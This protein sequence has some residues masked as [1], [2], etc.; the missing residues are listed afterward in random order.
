MAI[1]WDLSWP[2]RAFVV[3]GLAITVRPVPPTTAARRPSC[4]PGSRGS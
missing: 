4:P 3:V 2:V 1:W